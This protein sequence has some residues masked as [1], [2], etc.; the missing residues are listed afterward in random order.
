MRIARAALVAWAVLGVGGRA[1]AGDLLETYE[2]ALRSDPQ[3]AGAEAN[4][5]ARR[6]SVPQAR[7]ALLP[8]VNG[9]AS[10]SRTDNR[11]T[12]FT[13][14]PDP[15]DPGG[16]VFGESES[17]SEN[18]NR[19][20]GVSLSQSIYDHANWTRLR[21]ARVRESQADLELEALADELIV[22]TADT[23]FAALTAGE[24]LAAARSQEVA[25]ARQL[26]Q[27]EVRMRAGLATITDVH[28]ARAALEGARASAIVAESAASDAEEALAEIIGRPAG[29]LEVLR[30]DYLPTAPVPADEQA[31]VAQAR[32]SNPE[33][34]AAARGLEASDVEV[35]TARAGH[36][37][38]LS[39]TASYNRGVS[40]G[41]S[42]SNGVDFPANGENDGATVTLQLEVPIFS[43]GSV[44]SGVRQAMYVRD[45]TRQQLERQRRAVARQV[46][47]AYRA[48]VSGIGEIAARRAALASARSA[49]AASE[50]GLGAGTRTVVEVLITQQNLF[51]ARRAY[52]G[53]RH[54]H[55]VNTLR[56]KQA[57]GSISIEDLRAVNALLVAA[58][59]PGAAA[60][61][62][63]TGG[64][65]DAVR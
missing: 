17:R 60:A 12:S 53:A 31:W 28:E 3:M 50:A 59:A 15:E 8:R 45:A 11:S 26:D 30:D 27:A 9:S 36:Y 51:E 32:R 29:R 47:R 18:T 61:G 6:E 16:T 38:R 34:L 20:V 58:P 46:R 56:L 21:A 5:L 40:T 49:Y 64:A 14:S 2:I 7:A 24:E 52:A 48:V 44:R 37:P 43:G 19:S 63:G 10:I 42:S 57:A 35:A 13:T 33:L 25:I 41:S 23:Y 65:R 55:L 39:A 54:A 22:R 1:H 62:T 4:H